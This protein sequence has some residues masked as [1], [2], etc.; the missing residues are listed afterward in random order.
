MPKASKTQKKSAK[1]K[2]SP[3]IKSVKIKKIA[4]KASALNEASVK[5]VPLTEKDIQE[6]KRLLI[7]KRKILFGDVMHMEEEIKRDRQSFGS[8][9]VSNFAE[10]GSDNFEQELTLGFIENEA[11]ELKEIDEALLRIEAGNYGVCE[12]L[13]RPI[14]RERLFAIPYTRYSIEYA[15]MKEEG[16]VEEDNYP[17]EEMSAG[18]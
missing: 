18:E 14:S 16:L 1:N 12:G 17:D 2:K 8:Q 3:K 15:Q 4:S 9:D 6:L 7:A 5:V 10:L 13:N 11:A